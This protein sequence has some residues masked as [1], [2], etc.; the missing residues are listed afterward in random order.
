MARTITT[1]R[2]ESIYSAGNVREDIT[3]IDELASSIQAV[4]L[5]SPLLVTGTKEAPTLIAGH[6]RLAAVESLGWDEV[7]VIFLDTEPSRSRIATQLVENMQREGLSPLE[8]AAGLAE[9]V[10][11]LG[12]QAAAAEATG[13]S[14]GYV[15]KALKLLE[16]DPDTQAEV[17]AGNITAQD[18]YELA[19]L[20]DSKHRREAVIEFKAGRGDR[21][22][23]QI[24]HA[25][26]VEARPAAEAKAAKAVAGQKHRKGSTVLTL[27]KVKADHKAAKPIEGWDGITVDWDD[28]QAEPCNAVVVG[29]HY[30]F[31][32]PDPTERVFCL[33]PARHEP[34]GESPVKL[35]I[36]NHDQEAAE[37]E[38]KRQAEREAAEARLRAAV[39]Y[40]AG[41]TDR[42]VALKVLAWAALRATSPEDLADAM[43]AVGI[44]VDKK[45]VLELDHRQAE[46]ALA[47][48]LDE[49][50]VTDLWRTAILIATSQLV[51]WYRPTDP[52]GRAIL[53]ITGLEARP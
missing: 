44:E 53:D 3:N 24:R 47:T 49:A 7:E 29:F 33:E 12:T 38:A 15:S 50:K 2:V 26:E 18:A 11:E 8:E 40:S 13:R 1:A 41:L 51:T 19:R 37:R 39:S 46:E 9:L 36:T 5:L 30:P 43:A 14:K 4:G 22:R 10:T 6:R 52:F 25:L 21:A 34:D 28:H 42:N 17:S 31:A 23:N 20:T 16:L 32:N 48:I 35:I 45:A 27:T